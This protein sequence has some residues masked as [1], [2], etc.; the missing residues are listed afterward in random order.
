MSTVAL[1]VYDTNSVIFWHVQKTP[2]IYRVSAANEV[3]EAVLDLL[4]E[5]SAVF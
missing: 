4:R 2:A 1:D 3:L 5:K